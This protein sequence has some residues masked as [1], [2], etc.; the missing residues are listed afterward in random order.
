MRNLVAAVTNSYANRVISAFD[1]TNDAAGRRTAISHSGEA[2]GDL[3]GATD[4]YGYNSRDVVISARRTKNGEIIHGF[5]E[6][7]EY[8]PIGNRIS[9]T[10]YN[11]LGE[12][13][14]SQYS[15]NNLNQYTS[16]T[17]PGY[18]AIRGH[19]DADATVTVNEKPTY[20]YGEYFF[21]SDEFDNSQFAVEAELITSAVLASPTNGQDEVAFVTSRVHIAKSPQLFEYD[22][23]GN[24]LND[25]YYTF[26]YDSANRLEKVST[27][28]VLV[29]T[30]IYDAKSR[31]VRKVT[32]EATMAFFYDD[33][34]LVEERIAYTNGTVSTIRYFW[35][36]GLS[37]TLQ[38]AG[39]IGGLLYL[40]VDGA[41]YVPCYDSNGNITHYLDSN[42]STAAQ[43]IYDTFG[44]L[45]LQSGSL[46]DFF[47]HRF[48]TKYFDVETGLYYY[49]YR[50]YHPCLMRWLNRDPLE[51]NGGMNQ[52]VFCQNMPIVLFDQLGMFPSSIRQC[53]RSSVAISFVFDGRTLSGSGFSA[54]AASGRPQKTH[55]PLVL[56]KDRL[57]RIVGTRATY[58]YEFNYSKERQKIKNVGPIPEGTY[59][60]LANEKRTKW[61]SVRTHILRHPGWG[62]YGWSL[63]PEPRTETYGRRGFFIH[64]GSEWGSAGCI[65]LTNGDSVLSAFLDG[66]CD[67]YI[68]VIVEYAVEKNTIF[69]TYTYRIPE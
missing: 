34:N 59:Y 46:A 17:V 41:V 7:F 62:D 55:T 61:N 8:D 47:R 57:G 27:N 21:G 20:R 63:H 23:D 2:I 9:S 31:R 38:D 51:E 44:N 29:L 54:A 53:S 35:D 4:S 15:A 12:P 64:G 42:G 36:K 68:P 6:D 52:Y 1:Y 13:K 28:G 58:G 67:C 50:F 69:E 45:I 37:G 56:I 33:W 24:L 30:N 48:S 25:G 39:G 14:T 5:N 49:G 18:A 22:D 16:R 19:A 43:Y 10:T 32:P 40:T 3:S 26:T 60:I 11:E 65:D 66:L